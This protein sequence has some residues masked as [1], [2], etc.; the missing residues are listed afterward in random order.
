MHKI[1]RIKLAG[2]FQGIST[3]FNYFVT[4]LVSTGFLVS[5]HILICDNATIHLTRENKNLADILW[6]EKKI[7][8]YIYLHTPELNTIEL[9]F[10]LLGDRLRQ[11]N[12]RHMSHQMKD[13]D[14]CC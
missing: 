7:L 10:Q 13:D 9:V 11:S 5:C 14:F 4:Q 12:A 2:K 8:F 6:E 3:A 1:F